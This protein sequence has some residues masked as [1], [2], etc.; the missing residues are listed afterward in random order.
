MAA[1]G[2]HPATQPLYLRIRFYTENLIHSFGAKMDDSFWRQKLDP[3]K[4][5]SPS[6][7]QIDH[8]PVVNNVRIFITSLL[9][10]SL[11]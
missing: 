4:I 9:K 11:K 7:I 10:L 6:V 3:H 5:G 8:S 1:T 2:A